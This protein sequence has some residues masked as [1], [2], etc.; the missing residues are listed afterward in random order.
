MYKLILS[1]LFLVV[2]VN[3]V[4]AQDA[5]DYDTDIAPILSA[6]CASCHNAGQNSFNSSSYDAVMSSRSPSTRYDALHVI[7]GN[8]DQSPLVDKIEPNPQYGTRMPT[9]GS[10]SDSEIALIRRW[11]NEGANEVATSTEGVTDEPVEFE[12]LG[13]Y[14]NPFNPTTQISFRSPE[15]AQ[16]DLEVFNVAGV[17]VG[18]FSGRASAG[19]TI[20]PV[21]MNDQ[22]TGVYFYRL[23]VTG[24]GR[25]IWTADG[26]MTL[27]R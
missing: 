11:I 3:A 18:S 7:P 13:N 19:N 24:S 20:I 10:L 21:Q 16:Y 23:S 1:T 9:G 25:Q 26:R 27:I 14:P 15:S 6:N 4:Y 2:T 17:K 22:P 8:A 12:L 5:V